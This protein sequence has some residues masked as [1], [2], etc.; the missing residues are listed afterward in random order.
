RGNSRVGTQREPTSMIAFER[1]KGRGTKIWRCESRSIG[2]RCLKISSA[3]PTHLEK[4]YS[5]FPRWHLPT[6]RFL[7][8]VKP[9]QEKGRSRVHRR[10]LR[11]HSAIADRFRAV[12]A[13][14]G[15]LHRGDPKTSGPF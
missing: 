15:R 9:A 13:R 12:R 1:K 4:C 6:P 14:E 5:E 3:R 8:L 2:T 11:S 10:Q 7:F